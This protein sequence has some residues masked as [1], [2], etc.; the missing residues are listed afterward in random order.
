MKLTKRLSALALA[1]AMALSLAACGSDDTQSTSSTAPTDSP[2]AAEGGVYRE[3]YAS[4]VSTL[5]YLITGNTNDFQICANVV[6]CLVEY[7]SYGV[8]QPALAES[9]EHNEDNTVW[10]FHIRQGVKW[11]DSTGAE[12]ADVTAN[13]WVSAAQYANNAAN[14]SAT[15]YMYDGYVLNAGAYYNYT[16][17]LLELESATDGTD[18][19]GNPVKLNADGEVIE[20]VA[21]VAPEDIGVK[22]LDEYTLEYTLEKSC[23]YFPSL[24]SY[25][26]YMPV[27]GPFLEEQ[28][29]NFGVA[30]DETTL[31]YCGAYILS[32]FQPQVNRTLTKNASYW[33]AEHV[34]IDEIQ[35]TYNSEAN[36]LAATMYLSGETDYA[37]ISSSLLSAY[38]AD[39]STA[40]LIH[41]KRPDVSY[42][43]FYLF[44]F[45]ANF[46]AEYEPENWTLAVNNENF[47]LSILH[48]LDRATAL[49]VSDPYNASSLL[50][51]TITPATFAVGDGLDFTQY[52]ALKEISDGDSFNQELALQ[53]KEAAMA[54]LT[55]VGATFPVKVLMRYNPSTTD[56]DKECTV[57]EQQLE[58]LLGTDY[59]DVII[60]AGPDTNFLAE[61]R[62]SG[63]YAFMKCNWGADFADPETWTEPFS[64]TSTYSFIYESEDPTTQALYDEYLSLVDTAKAITDDEGAR[65]TAFAGAEAFLIEHGFAIPFS[66]N[67][68]VYLCQ[69]LNPFEAQYAPYGM[70]T[71]RFKGQHLQETSMGMDEFNALYETWLADCAAAQEA[72]AG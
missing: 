10:T 67:S 3:L 52:P 63:D 1:G 58:G 53:Y 42:S 36:T 32:D 12:V 71:L 4:E 40:S 72:A 50:N 43:Y 26:C 56:W 24:L 39:D 35:Y 19:N 16:A 48:A 38:M 60:E 65:Y 7:D 29:A 70:A 11:V 25:A 44:N 13:D 23:P 47:R 17:Y 62:R 31:L 8:I 22:A 33:D 57:V 45:D 30:N 5:N 27:Y 28:G 68:R 54:E 41:S 64:E 2:T 9:W 59:I 61:V 55:A 20:E 6:D 69:N 18:E 51:N 15:Q 49:S 46:D 66:V 21:A 34:Y 37:E 14:D